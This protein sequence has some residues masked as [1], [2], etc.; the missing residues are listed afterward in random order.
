MA[1]NKASKTAGEAQEQPKKDP[2]PHRDPANHP[3]FSP[4]RFIKSPR[5]GTEGCEL[6]YRNPSGP[7]PCLMASLALWRIAWRVVL[8]SLRARATVSSVERSIPSE[9]S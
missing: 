1:E 3:L 8:I 9:K 2:R 7:P 4:F 5:S 6:H